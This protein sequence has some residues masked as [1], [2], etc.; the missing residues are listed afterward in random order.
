MSG[1]DEIVRKDELS[2]IIAQNLSSYCGL[3]IGK[4]KAYKILRVVLLS[5][6]EAAVRRKVSIVGIFSAE[7]VE[8]ISP[9]GGLSR[10]LRIKFSDLII[11]K[12][13]G[14]DKNSFFSEFM[15][16]IDM[17]KENTYEEDAKMYNEDE[18]FGN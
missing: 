3:D 1:I 10:S 13:K 15:D 4:A 14:I 11:N 6:F 17:E 12:I 7:V 2:V 16:D 5:I 8:R 18:L 9:H